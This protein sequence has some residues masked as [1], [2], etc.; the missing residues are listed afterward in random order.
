MTTPDPGGG[1]GAAE[2]PFFV[3]G[4]LLPGEPNHD[5]FLRGRTAGE[6]PAVLPRAL[7]YEGPGY[8]YA[9]E[10]HGRVHGM[11]LVAAP[12]AYGEL[13]GLLDHLE[14]YLGPGHPR[15]L[16]ERVVREV[17]LPAR[18]AAEPGEPGAPRESGESGAARKSG[19]P[20]RAWVYLA[21][22]AVTR[23]LRTG[24]VLIPE[25]RWT[26]GRAPGGS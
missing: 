10:G 4:T 20:V 2:L 13:L 18:G 7:L 12:G 21:A 5:L 9:I 15:N 26:T 8:P 11:L 3:Y 1:P 19:A 6:R 22:T 23:S 24:G 17:E 14:E 16:Y 25:G